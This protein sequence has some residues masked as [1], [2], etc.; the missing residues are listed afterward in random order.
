MTPETSTWPSGPLR[1]WDQHHT[2]CKGHPSQLKSHIFNIKLPLALL[3][4]AL[5]CLGWPMKN[6]TSDNPLHSK[7]YM[8]HDREPSLDTVGNT[9]GCRLPLLKKSPTPKVSIYN[10]EKMILT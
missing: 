5:T 3:T 7:D 8:Q 9:P 2:H 10:G 1:Q 6:G 4:E